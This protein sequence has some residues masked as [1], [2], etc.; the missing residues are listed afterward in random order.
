MPVILFTY[1]GLLKYLYSITDATDISRLGTDTLILFQPAPP[2]ARTDVSKTGEG[3]TQPSGPVCRGTR[4][5]CRE[6]CGCQPRKLPLSYDTAHSVILAHTCLCIKSRCINREKV[7][8][9]VGELF[10]PLWSFLSRSPHLKCRGVW[11]WGSAIPFSVS[12]GVN[13]SSC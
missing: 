1:D 6:L 13:I 2:S 4:S 7:E 10:K 3:L 9:G 11:G 5:Q 12:S 8:G